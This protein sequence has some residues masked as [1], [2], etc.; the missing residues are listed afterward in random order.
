M[1]WFTI[2]SSTSSF[3]R[4]AHQTALSLSYPPLALGEFTAPSLPSFSLLTFILCKSKE[5][6][7]KVTLHFECVD[8]ELWCVTMESKESV[9]GLSSYPE[10]IRLVPRPVVAF[11]GCRPLHDTVIS[12]L[13]KRPDL[14]GGKDE[15]SLYILSLEV[16]EGLLERKKERRQSYE[17][18]TPAGIFNGVWLHKHTKQVPAAVAVFFN[19]DDDKHWKTRENEIVSELEAVK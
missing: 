2:T 11:V 17:G 18:Y 6:K 19:L 8:C 12:V 1:L 14:Y 16:G 9:Q 13:S 15:P 10:E 4:T 5:E 3:K 7:K